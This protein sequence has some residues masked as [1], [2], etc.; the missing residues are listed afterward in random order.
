MHKSV[1]QCDSITINHLGR[2][3]QNTE[4]NKEN[5]EQFL[6]YNPIERGQLDILVLFLDENAA[7][8]DPQHHVGAIGEDEPDGAEPRCQLIR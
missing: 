5:E 3:A 7:V 6:W 8:N 4:Q 2:F 1:E